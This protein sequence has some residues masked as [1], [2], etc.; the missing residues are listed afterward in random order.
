MP[1][2]CPFCPRN[3]N[4]AEH[5]NPNW[6]SQM[7]RQRNGPGTFTMRFGGLYPERTVKNR[8]NQTVRVCLACNTGWMARLE[9]RAKPALTAMA[10]GERIMMGVAGQWVL[11][12]WLMKQA[13]MQEFVLPPSSE[14]RISNASQRHL[15]KSGGIPEGWLVAIAGFEGDSHLGVEHT[16]GRPKVRVADDGTTVGHVALHTFQ[17]ECFV[18][19]VLLHSCAE[20]PVVQNFLGGPQ[21]AAELLTRPLLRWPSTQTLRPEWMDTIKNFV[22]VSAGPGHLGVSA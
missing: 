4:T 22:P 15:I 13:V 1:R 17:F 11:T 7:Y 2:R 21:Y 19:Q 20:V 14:L 5:V 6:L 16:I 10:N 12:R 9:A 8:F 3:A 18:G